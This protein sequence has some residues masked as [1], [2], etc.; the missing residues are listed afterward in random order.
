MGQGGVEK[1][2]VLHRYLREQPE[3]DRRLIRSLKHTRLVAPD[4]RLGRPLCSSRK[5]AIYVSVCVCSTRMCCTRTKFCVPERESQF[6]ALRQA[7]NIEAL[8]GERFYATM[9]RYMGWLVFLSVLFEFSHLAMKKLPIS[10]LSNHLLN[11]MD[12]AVSIVRFVLG[13]R[14]SKTWMNG[15]AIQTSFTPIPFSL[16][17]TLLYYR[18]L[19]LS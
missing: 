8:E 16:H 5:T 6:Y 7:A 15:G 12:F 14:R 2:L 10:T 11:N 17:T 18:P 4:M 9:K 19:Y 3:D 1:Y 13:S